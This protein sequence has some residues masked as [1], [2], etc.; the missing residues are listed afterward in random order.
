MK[1]T[2]FTGLLA[3]ASLGSLSACDSFVQDID[4]PIDLI[5]SDSLNV[6]GQVGFLITGVK[7]GFNDA[8]D[9]LAVQ[10]DLLADVGEFNVNVRD[11]T[12]PTFGEIDAG[13]IRLDN[14]SVDGLYGSINE[15]RFNADDLL[16]RADA[17]TFTGNA[18]GAESERSLRFAGNFH[19]GIARY[20]LATYFSED[21]VNG[22]APISTDQNAPGPVIPAAELY[23]QADAKLA[24]AAGLVSG[25]YDTRVINTLRARIALFSG[26]R[27]RAGTLAASG[28]V[29]GD[30]PYVANFTAAS[31]NNWWSQAGAGR[32]QVSINRRFVDYDTVDNRNLVVVT[33]NASGSDTRTFYRQGLY[34]TAVEALPFV[35]WQENSLIRAEAALIGG[36]GA[37]AAVAFVNPVL[38]N[39]GVDTIDSSL[40]TQD[41]LIQVRDRE[42]YTQGQRLVDMRRFNLPFT[43]KVY[44]GP[45]ATTLGT[46]TPLGPFRYLP[47]TETERNNN[48]NL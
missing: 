2:L 22:G 39:R 1:K 9:N 18:A 28:L 4:P 19:G 6:Q 8:Y 24:A 33:P 15:Y 38:A 14:N 10:S 25:A 5:P 30:A 13:A 43:Y 36:S 29:A 21:G 11:S 3:V 40:L 17:I 31:T 20:F 23:A 7:E 44:A 32:T 27:A 12:F 26:D 16:V 45:P 48:P 41:R 46:V 35:T 47:L 34:L 37:D 42:L